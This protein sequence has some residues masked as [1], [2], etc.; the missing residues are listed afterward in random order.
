MRYRFTKPEWAVICVIV[1]ILAGIILP[2]IPEYSRRYNTCA[3]CRLGRWD[4]WRQESR[5]SDHEDTECTKWFREHIERDHEHVWVSNSVIT[6]RNIFGSVISIVDSDPRAIFRISPSQQIQIFEHIPD[7]EEAA[8]VFQLVGRDKGFG[9]HLQRRHAQVTAHILR[10]WAE[11]EF[12]ENWDDVRSR[13][14]RA[15]PAEGADEIEQEHSCGMNSTLRG[16][17]SLVH[18]FDQRFDVVGVHFRHDAVAQVED[19]ARTSG[20]L[21]EHVV[22]AGT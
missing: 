20:G 2:S 22:R 6:Q 1:A 15:R 13:I 17:D 14:D 9:E 21:R 11:S 4:Y 7:A 10:D 12:A 5:W 19:V 18:H 8:R 16:A 3:L